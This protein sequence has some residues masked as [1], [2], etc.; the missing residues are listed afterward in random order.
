MRQGW[1]RNKTKIDQYWGPH[2]VPAESV[3]VVPIEVIESLRQAPDPSFPIIDDDP[4]EWVFARTAH[5]PFSV[6]YTSH[7][8]HSG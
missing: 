2:C 4:A 8:R 3:G 7:G 1:I 6:N 5:L